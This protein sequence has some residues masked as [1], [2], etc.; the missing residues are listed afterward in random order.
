MARIVEAIG[1]V[2]EKRLSCVEAADRLGMSEWHFRRLRDGYGEGD[3][4]AIVGRRRGRPASNK[5]PEEIAVFV[6]EHYR[7]GY[8][9]MSSKQCQEG[10]RKSYPEFCYGYTWTKSVLC[11][12]GLVKP[13]RTRGLH[14]KKRPGSA[15]PGMLV[16]QAGSRHDWFRGRPAPCDLIVT[17][18]DATGRVLSAFSCEQEGTASRCRG[19]A[20]TISESC[21]LSSL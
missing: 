2:R 1:R 13:A 5:V 10:L 6:V 14:R 4:A 19:P 18:D 12:R 15:L 8:F 16:F 9:E 21:L 17:L 3:A 20:E 7:S 11:L